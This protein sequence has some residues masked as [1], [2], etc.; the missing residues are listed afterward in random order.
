MGYPIYAA[1]A[2]VKL[3]DELEPALVVGKV[4]EAGVSVTGLAGPGVPLPARAI[5]MLELGELL[6]RTKYAARAPAAVGVNDIW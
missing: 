3:M 4:A 6:P 1:L 2:R 5:A